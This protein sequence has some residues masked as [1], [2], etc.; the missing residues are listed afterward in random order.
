MCE[1]GG[2]TRKEERDEKIMKTPRREG[3]NEHTIIVRFIALS[4]MDHGE[5]EGKTKKR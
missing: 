2:S 5:R 3:M 1:K 4:A